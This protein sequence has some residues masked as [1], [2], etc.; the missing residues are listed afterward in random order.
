MI[1]LTTPRGLPVPVPESLAE[2]PS[3]RFAVCEAD[4][5]KA[6]YEENGYVIVKSVL[7]PEV[8]DTQRRLWEE[9]VKPFGGYI[10]RQATAKAE[11]HIFN[12]NGW[13]MNPILN[14]QSVDP[15]HFRR[16]RAY[17]TESVLAAPALRDVFKT[18]LRE[19]PK[20]VQSMYFE[21]NSATWEHQDSYY[22]DSERVGEMA[23]AWIAVESIAPCAGRFF[24]CPKSHKIRLDD[25]SLENNIADHHEI[26]ISSVVDKIKNLKLDIRAPVLEKGD[27]LFWNALTIHGSLDSQ[28]PKHSRSSITCHAIP[29]SR[30]FLS[31]QTRLRDVSTDEVNGTRVFRPKDLGTQRNRLIFQVETKFPSLFYWAK[32]TALRQVFRHKSA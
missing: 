12:E 25:H 24:I 6:Y 5:L 8:C 32:R 17:A 20:V 10:Y 22:L 19:T 3:R 9:E 2:D 4:E 16:F 29:S 23:A 7:A 13:V 18:L 21:G 30:L 15:K 28:D 1:N 31:H 14:L 27:V 11:R 26:Y